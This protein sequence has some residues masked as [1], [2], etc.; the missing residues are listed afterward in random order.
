MR[1]FEQ[2]NAVSQL[3]LCCPLAPIRTPS[4]LKNSL[5]RGARP[6]GR[7]TR[8]LAWCSPGV[9]TLAK[10]TQCSPLRWGTSKS[11]M[12]RGRLRD[13][14]AQRPASIRPS[15]KVTLRS[16]RMLQARVSSILD[17]SSGCSKC[18][19]CCN[20]YIRMLQVYVIKCFFCFLEVCCKCMF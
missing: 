15:N 14:A 2:K 9:L 18:F 5:P 7:P 11:S 17:V 8:E 4:N 20:S 19:T 6:T 10:V 16:K 3:L 12:L 1:T 13:N